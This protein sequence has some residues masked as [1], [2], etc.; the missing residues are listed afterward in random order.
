EQVLTHCHMQ[1]KF[2]GFTS[3]WFPVTN[4]ISQ[5]DPLS[6]LIN[7]V[8][9]CRGRKALKELTL[10]FVNDM[11]FIAIGKDFTKTHTILADMLKHPGGGFDWSKAH[12]SCFETNKFTLMDF[13]MNR[14]KPRPDMHIQGA[15]IQPVYT[16]RFLGVILD[17]ELH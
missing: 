1:L 15:V 9:P 4:R 13:S 10:V 2:D 16:H 17:Q 12:N 7:V 5:G 3:D 11:A 8:T 14:C 6:N